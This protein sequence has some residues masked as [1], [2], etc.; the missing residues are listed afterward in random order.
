MRIRRRFGEAQAHAEKALAINPKDPSAHGNLATILRHQGKFDEALARFDLALSILPTYVEM[1]YD[2]SSLKTFAAGDPDLAVME[3]LAANAERLPP[4]R[5]HFI[6][7]GLAKALEDI[8][9][10]DRAF[11]HW[12][13]GNKL[14][15]QEFGQEGQEEQM[16][17]LLV[18][19]FT[20]DLCRQFATAGDPSRVPIFIVGMPRSGTS[21]IEQILA[22][23]PLVEGGGELSTL[24]S[25]VGAVRDASRRPIP[26][27]LFLA[28]PRA[29]GLKRLG[30][31]Y[32]AKLPPLP[33]GKTRMT[34][35]MPGNFQYAGLIR[36]I[37]PNAKIIHAVRDPVD[38]CLSCFTRLFSTGQAFSYDL[39]ELGRYY[40]L[41]RR[42]ADHW[43]AVLPPGSMLD[44]R[45]EEVVDNLE[46]QARRLLDYCGLPWDPACLAFHKNERLVS[47]ASDVQVRRPIYRSS[48]VR[49]RRY[50]KHLGPLLAELG[51]LA[52]QNAAPL[53][54]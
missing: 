16:V 2:R 41:Y 42:L 40:R 18:E 46:Q 30:E 1:Y 7:F 36:L 49:W 23:H 53:N 9:Q 34:D 3:A 29:A 31:Q 13:Q 54:P 19:L 25:V 28:H 20:P 12:L 33:E 43:Q 22:S 6:H 37:L 26:Y 48:V 32:L 17:R 47:T 21:L 51:D 8:G 44:V 50:E 52:G 38:T 10:Y 24:G 4:G 11:A 45:Y 14:K 35:K 15:R 39:A 5:K 27:P